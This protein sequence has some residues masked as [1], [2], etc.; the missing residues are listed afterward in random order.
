MK[1]YLIMLSS[2]PWEDKVAVVVEEELVK[3]CGAAQSR[4]ADNKAQEALGR[5]TEA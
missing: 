4:K 5:T 2:L 3:D 1:K